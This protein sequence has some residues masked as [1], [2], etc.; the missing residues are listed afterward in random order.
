MPLQEWAS[1]VFL[2][3]KF[4]TACALRK[5][6]LPVSKIWTQKCGNFSCSYFVLSP[7]ANL[8]TNETIFVILIKENNALCVSFQ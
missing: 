7:S 8:Q 6:I 3:W 4:N 2:L 1:Y 5:N